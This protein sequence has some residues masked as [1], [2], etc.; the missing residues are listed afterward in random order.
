M[1]NGN[2]GVRPSATIVQFPV[3][4]K[5]ARDARR[6]TVRNPIATADIE[7]GKDLP[8]V[9]FGS[10]WYHEAATLDARDSTDRGRR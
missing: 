8:R 5:G 9:D 6:G 3:G 1:D 2:G 10:G 4:G 7:A